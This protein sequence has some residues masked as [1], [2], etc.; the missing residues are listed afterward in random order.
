[1]NKIT[2]ISN[3]KITIWESPFWGSKV[4]HLTVRN[5]WIKNESLLHKICHIK[6]TINFKQPVILSASKKC[7]NTKCKSLYFHFYVY[8]FFHVFI[9]IF[10]LSPPSIPLYL[11]PFLYLSLS[12]FSSPHIFPPPL[13]LSLTVFYLKKAIIST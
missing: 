8:T 11:S 7:H 2:I 6:E 13:S 10:N 9:C 12:Y 4:N 3:L 1:M 5:L